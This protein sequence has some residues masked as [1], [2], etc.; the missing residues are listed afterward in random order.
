[1]KMQNRTSKLGGAVG[2]DA[3]VV[4]F[5]FGADDFCSTDRARFRILDVFVSART[6]LIDLNDLGNN[7][8]ATLNSDPVANFH[9]E[10]ADFIDVMQ[11]RVANRRTADWNWLQLRDGCQFAS[12]AGLPTDSF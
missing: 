10:T 7:I 8:A 5:A 1:G 6:I 9:T 12:T 3:A 11:G 4:H 2:V